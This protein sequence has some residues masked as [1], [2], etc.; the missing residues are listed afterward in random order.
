[1]TTI[2]FGIIGLGAIAGRHAE[3]IA[4]L[5]GGLLRACY[6]RDANKARAFA[7]K[8][9]GRPYSDLAAF[10][11]DPQVDVVNVCTPSGAHLEPAVAAARA[12]KHVLVEK[13]LE[14][15]PARCRRIID[16]CRR[17]RVKLVT[18]FQ[19]RFKE[20]NLAIR[21][22][23]DAGR[24]GKLVNASTQVKWYRDQ[25]YYDSGAWRGTWALDGG[26]CLMNQGIHAVDLLIWLVGDVVEVSAYAN[27]PTRK[28]IEVETNLVAALKFKNGA[29]GIIEASTEIY[30]GYPRRLEIC[31]T[32]GTVAS[33]EEDL[34]YW[35]F[36]KKRA[37]DAQVLEKF[38][39]KRGSSGGAADPMA[40][41]IE[42]HRCQFQELTDVLL[43]R[44][45]NLT[46]AGAEGLRSVK[47]I[48]AIYRS[49]RTGKPV[50]CG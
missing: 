24:L 21:E 29:L 19:N 3:A 17:R 49:V 47:L 10:L 46:C 16:A 43:K 23:V 42:A 13:P 27:R 33:V 15:T 31:G 5:D 39:V 6:S 45:R 4:G 35:D 7:A 34:L 11:S 2:G 1:M 32:T 25:R 30:P 18:A 12:G 28:R 9:G 37:A 40:F 50:R 14:V 20:V 8:H 38:A 22:A 41:S 48:D 36:A 44:R 26:G